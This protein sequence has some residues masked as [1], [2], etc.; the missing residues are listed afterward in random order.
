[1][2]ATLFSLFM[3]LLALFCHGYYTTMINVV[4]RETRRDISPDQTSS[5]KEMVPMFGKLIYRKNPRKFQDLPSRQKL[6]HVY[7]KCNVERTVSV[8][9]EFKT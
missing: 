4:V 7:P 6:S 8:L 2:L 9:S 5:A 1:M 3:T